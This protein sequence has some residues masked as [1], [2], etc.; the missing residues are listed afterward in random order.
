MLIDTMVCSS[1]GHSDI[2]HPSLLWCL[3]AMGMVMLDVRGYYGLYRDGWLTSRC[4]SL[5]G[6]TETTGNLMSDY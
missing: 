6:V 4:P 5:L 1:D 2:S 3:V